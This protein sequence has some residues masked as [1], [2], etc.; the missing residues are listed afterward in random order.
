LGAVGSAVGCLVEAGRKEGRIVERRC[1]ERFNEPSDADEV[2]L[3][4]LG[5]VEV[6][7]AQ[8]SASWLGIGE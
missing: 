4:K 1:A 6:G 8:V 3:L 7:A 5:S 2:G